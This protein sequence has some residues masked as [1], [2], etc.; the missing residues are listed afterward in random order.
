MVTIQL[1]EGCF[2]SSQSR[3]RH[4]TRLNRQQ[5]LHKRVR[6]DQVSL[7]SVPVCLINSVNENDHRL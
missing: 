6:M 1:A 2:R 3:V 7:H 5:R 4:A